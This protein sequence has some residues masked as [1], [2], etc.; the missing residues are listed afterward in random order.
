MTSTVMLKDDNN[1]TFLKIE[2][3]LY[4]KMLLIQKLSQVCIIWGIFVHKTKTMV[5]HQK[6]KSSSVWVDGTIRTDSVNPLIC[7]SG[8][9]IQINSIQSHSQCYLEGNVMRSTAWN[10]ICIIFC[11]RFLEWLFHFIEYLPLKTPFCVFL[12]G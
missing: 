9:K 1:I 3:L 10:I 2:P 4:I 8:I 7:Q 11:I 5:V 6:A 12:H